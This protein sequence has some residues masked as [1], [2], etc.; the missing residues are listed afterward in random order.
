M[1]RVEARSSGQVGP[2]RL[3]NAAFA[4]LQRC[5]FGRD[6]D[7]FLSCLRTPKAIIVKICQNSQMSMVN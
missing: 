4:L 7:A 2:E 6:G 5:F 1:K 3:A